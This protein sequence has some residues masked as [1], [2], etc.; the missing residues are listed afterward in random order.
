MRLKALHHLP[1][2]AAMVNLRLLAPPPQLLRGERLGKRVLLLLGEHHAKRDLL[3]LL[4]LLLLLVAVLLLL[5]RLIL[6]NKA[7]M[8]QLLSCGAARGRV[9]RLR[10][11]C[12]ATQGRV[13]GDSG[14]CGATQGCG[15]L[16]GRV[17][18]EGDLR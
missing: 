12:G 10:G 18:E 16:T 1:F 6:L 4:L 14:V 2:R 15:T 9:G 13:W 3:L 17:G 11:V 8:G 5:R 7:R